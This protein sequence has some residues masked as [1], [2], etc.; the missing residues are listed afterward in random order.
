MDKDKFKKQLKWLVTRVTVAGIINFPMGSALAIGIVTITGGNN[1]L[2]AG[3]LPIPSNLPN[4]SVIKKIPYY[5]PTSYRMPGENYSPEFS[6]FLKLTVNGDLATGYSDVYKTNIDGIGIR[7]EVVKY[8]YTGGWPTKPGTIDNNGKTFE[9]RYNYAYNNA[10]MSIDAYLIKISDP[11][12]SAPLTS[13]PSVSITETQS[14]GGTTA[15]PPPNYFSGIATGQITALT[16]QPQD[17]QVN[18]GMQ[19]SQGFSG[20]GSTLQPV[21]FNIPLNNCPRGINTVLYRIDPTTGVA[22]QSDGVVVLNRSS[23]ASGVGVQIQDESGSPLKLSSD[24][25]FSAYSTAGGSFKIPL[26]AAYYQTD[27][28]ITAGSA[29][30]AVTFTMTY[31]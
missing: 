1:T 13:I 2:D 8:F 21:A 20:V 9:Y 26:K 23:T 14:D 29:N 27:S 5:G 4:G 15:T 12:K 6:A 7:F 16:C 30:T 19:H 10:A 25:S 28:K 18:M 3:N 24:I 31:Q 17:V 22:P 11:I